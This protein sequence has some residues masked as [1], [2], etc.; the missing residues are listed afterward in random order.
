MV[1]ILELVL[2]KV[3][4]SLGKIITDKWL[5]FGSECYLDSY[6]LPKVMVNFIA[7]SFLILS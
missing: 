1:L 2:R 7:E 3:K 6:V 4:V 5:N